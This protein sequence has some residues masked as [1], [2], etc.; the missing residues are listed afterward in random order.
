MSAHRFFKQRSQFGGQRMENREVFEDR[1]PPDS[2]A[3][4]TMDAR[5]AF[6]SGPARTAACD[7]RAEAKILL[8]TL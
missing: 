8:Q 7:A 5:A 4:P 2:A 3:D 1:A 6:F